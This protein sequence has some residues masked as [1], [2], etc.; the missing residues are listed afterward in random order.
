M[1][2]GVLDEVKAQNF[3]MSLMAKVTFRVPDP[4][5]SNPPARMKPFDSGGKELHEKQGNT[6]ALSNP[7]YV[8][9]FSYCGVPLDVGFLSL[10]RCRDAFLYDI[11]RTMRPGN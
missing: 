3:M 9:L 2:N 6:I 4:I 5:S 10:P 7:S 1:T 8:H 11:M